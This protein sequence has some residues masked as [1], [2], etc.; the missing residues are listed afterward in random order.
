MTAHEQLQFLMERENKALEE[1]LG[2]LEAEHEA[3]RAAQ[4]ESLAV[5]V[6]DKQRLLVELGELEVQRASL[7]GRVGQPSDKAGLAAFLAEADGTVAEKLQVSWGRTQA[8]LDAC[9]RQN[10][11]NG[12]WV[13]AG[14]KHVQQALSI[15]SGSAEQTELY[16]QKGSTHL[17][18]GNRTYAKV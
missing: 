3:L 5:A 12:Q 2:A 17:P 18:V 6:G 14:R 4:L 13:D 1:L 10:R 9:A 11:T 15:L 16:D 8:L 7:L